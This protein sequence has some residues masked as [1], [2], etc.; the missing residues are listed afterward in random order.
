MATEGERNCQT[1]ETRGFEVNNVP[2]YF[3]F[4]IALLDYMLPVA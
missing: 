1:F 2:K 3:M 4:R